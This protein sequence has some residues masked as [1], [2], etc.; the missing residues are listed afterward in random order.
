VDIAATARV[1]SP[2]RMEFSY[3][4]TVKGQTGAIATGRTS[5]AAVGRDGRPCRLPDRILEAFA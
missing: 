3:E 1:A 5:H 2:A 4:I